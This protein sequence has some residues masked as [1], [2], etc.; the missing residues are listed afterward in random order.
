MVEV[1]LARFYLDSSREALDGLLVVASPVKRDALVVVGVRILRVDLDGCG[2]VTD[3][4]VELTQLVVRKATVEEC[5]EVIGVNLECFRVEFD[6]LVVV[7]S[8]AGSIALRMVSFCLLLQVLVDL[9]LWH[10]WALTHWKGIGLRQVA[11]CGCSKEV[12]VSLQT[13]CFLKCAE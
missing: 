9:H 8:L 7:A 12:A 13:A 3:G 11:A 4:V 2:V 5:L 1:G 6:S 10:S